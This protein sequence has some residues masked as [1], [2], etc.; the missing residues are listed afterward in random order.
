MSEQNEMHYKD[1]PIDVFMINDLD[2]LN[3][4][5]DPLRVRILDLLRGEP[6]TVKQLNEILRIGVSK[7]YYHV[8]LL[9]QHHLIRVYETRV[10]NGILEKHYQATA[11]KLSV[12][13]A[14]FS[15]SPTTPSATTGL[16]V[17]LSAVLDET[18]KDIQHS[19][20][21]GLI[22]LANDA[23]LERQLFLGRCW[24]RLSPT[25]ARQF[26]ARLDALADEFLSIAPDPDSQELQWY[27][28][29][30]G[31]YPTHIEPGAPRQKLDT[32][33]QAASPDAPDMATEP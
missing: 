26:R 16:D 18:R 5:A 11:Y 27:E 4:V 31:L 28:W 6:Q 1:L 13:H 30:D 17:F 8:R 25:Q 20:R 22:E 33:Q 2:T 7:L 15:S 12:D 19:V 14:L 29:L 21:E 23:P 24:A 3:V 10:V 9:E 32:Y